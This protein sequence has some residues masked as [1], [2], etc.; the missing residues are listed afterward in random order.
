MQNIT[1]VLLSFEGPDQYAHAGGLG[2]RVAGMSQALA[3]MGFETHVF[4]IG[5]PELP[6]HEASPDGRLHLHR[7][8]QWISRYHPGGVYD[9]ENGKLE[10]WTRSVPQWIESN[11]LRPIATAGGTVIVVAEEWHTAASVIALRQ[12][13]VRNGWQSQV[14]LLWNANNTFGFDRIDWAAVRQS[15]AVSTVSKYMKHVLWRYGVDA[16]V[17]PNGIPESWLMPLDRRASMQLARA[18]RGRITLAKVARWDPDKRWEMAVDA[19]A[20]TKRLVG[21]PLFLAR[22]GTGQY[23]QTVIERARQRGLRMAT[24]NWSGDGTDEL[25]DAIQGAIDA[26]M[27]VLEGY[28]TEQQRQ[29]VFHTADAV[30]ANSGIEPFGLVGLETMAVGGVALVGCT[31]EDY[32]TPG[33]DAVSLQSNDPREIVHHVTALSANPDLSRRMRQ[34]ARATAARYTWQAVIKRVL[35]PYLGELGVM[36]S[37]GHDGHAVSERL[38]ELSTVSRS[39]EPVAGP[40]GPLAPQGRFPAGRSGARPAVLA[41]AHM[42][43]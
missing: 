40:P 27:L 8:C 23:G 31:G 16:R 29:V 18:T 35:L 4:F 36:A 33:Y 19:V 37:H 12:L 25:I 20:F 13:L 17:I 7:W 24:V 21:A 43:G 38:L 34:A 42:A 26:D 2:T 10:D 22:G 15:A 14:K 6:G 11:L 32:V 5:D 41:D 1:F 30:L 3:G 39:P 9:G 28:L